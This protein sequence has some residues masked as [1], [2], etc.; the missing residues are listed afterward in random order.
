MLRGHAK[1]HHVTRLTWG[2]TLMRR[3]GGWLLAACCLGVVSCARP[4]APED[5]APAY[6]INNA[7]TLRRCAGTLRLP[8]AL[9]MEGFPARDALQLACTSPVGCV[10][11]G[12]SLLV[13]RTDANTVA[14]RV[15]HHVGTFSTQHAVRWHGQAFPG[16]TLGHTVALLSTPET[17]VVLDGEL[18]TPRAFST[19]AV[20]QDETVVA[21]AS[22]G[23]GRPCLVV[24]RQFPDGAGV[25]RTVCLDGTVLPWD[26]PVRSA[27]G[28]VVGKQRFEL[29]G[30]VTVHSVDGVLWAAYDQTQTPPSISHVP[31]R[32]LVVQRGLAQ[33]IPRTGA[34]WSFE[35]GP[36]VAVL[37]REAGILLV[38]GTRGLVEQRGPAQTAPL[39]PN[40]G[41]TTDL[42]GRVLPQGAQ[43]ERIQVASDGKNRVAVLERVRLADCHAHDLVHL[44]VGQTVTTVAQGDR[45]RLF[46]QFVLGVL[47]WVEGDPDYSVPGDGDG[48]SVK[49]D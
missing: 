11:G 45:V 17:T 2:P 7:A 33:V 40:A 22:P 28:E 9:R 8:R 16:V 12:P 4:V 31:D 41:P 23:P 32:V 29:D 13:Y 37:N 15:G 25:T 30:T 19:P 35:L 10:A 21:V 1:G 47:Q 42:A 18:A 26:A 27:S 34:P 48:T 3:T 24:R 20:A 44:V 38:D 49:L 43:R 6:L 14:V 5:G 46:P 39:V 36:D